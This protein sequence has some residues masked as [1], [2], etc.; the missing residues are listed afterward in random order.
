MLPVLRKSHGLQRMWDATYQ[1]LGL[2]GTQLQQWSCNMM[3]RLPQLTAACLTLHVTRHTSH[4][5]RH[6]SHVTRHTSH[7]TRHTSHVPDVIA[8]IV[9]QQP[10]LPHGLDAGGSILQYVEYITSRNQQ[11]QEEL[12]QNEADTVADDAGQV[13]AYIKG[14]VAGWKEQDASALA[15]DDA[16]ERTMQL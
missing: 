3:L 8:S 7:V 10:P 2:T 14:G 15:F 9:D 1:V 12:Q 13:T 6:T 5:T 11:E 4:V 16:V